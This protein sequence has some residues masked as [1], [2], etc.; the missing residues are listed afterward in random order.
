[1]KRYRQTFKEIADSLQVLEVDWL[2]DPHAGAVISLLKSLPTDEP[3]TERHIVEMLK[4]DFRAASTALRLFLGMAKDEYDRDIPALF[5]GKGAGSKTFFYKAPEAY[6]AAFT[7]LGLLQ[8]INGEIQRPI[9]WCDRLIGLFEGGWGSARKGQLRGRLLEDFVQDIL[10]E[11][12]PKEQ[13][14]P[15]CQ[16]VGAN[17][18]SSEKADFAIPNATDAHILIEVKA[19]NATGSKQTDVLGDI[20][21]IVEQKRDD[22]AFLLVTDGI[23][24]KARASDLR[25]IVELQNLGKIRRIYTMAMAAELQAD[26][27]SL[28]QPFAL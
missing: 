9:L 14:V 11:V 19:F 20:F 10:L 1:M 26:L 6:V 21:R 5:E 27:I 3:V 2:V 22:T 23:S 7:K 25:K 4:A 18:T 16:F 24:W 12:F 8:K 17:G 13:I 15:R 28:K